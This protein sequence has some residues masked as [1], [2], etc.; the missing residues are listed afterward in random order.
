MELHQL[1]ASVRH[2]YAALLA[3]IDPEGSAHWR[4]LSVRE[5][6]ERPV[7]PTNLPSAN[8]QSFCTLAGARASRFH[9]GGRRNRYGA[10]KAK[11]PT[12]GLI[13]G[14]GSSPEGYASRRASGLS[15]PPTL[16]IHRGVERERA[17]LTSH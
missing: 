4:S 3:D 8:A 6:D 16:P 17:F 2:Q 7:S 10:R 5:G 14:Y 15:L 11:C 13:A 12:E 9:P 1:D